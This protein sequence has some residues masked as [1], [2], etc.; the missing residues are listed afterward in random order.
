ML[1][2]KQVVLLWKF[3][4]I[5][6]PPAYKVAAFTI[7]VTGTSGSIT[8]EATYDLFIKNIASDPALSSPANGTIGVDTEPQL[9]WN[10][11]FGALSYEYQI[12][13]LPNGGDV[14]ANG[15]TASTSITV[16][17]ELD[18]ATMYYWRVRSINDCGTSSWSEE[19]SFYKN[20]NY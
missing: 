9:I 5:K 6:N 15:S 8:R 16:A 20:E 17:T 10:S 1:S 3:S 11:E 12:S 4:E 7:K 13:L 2:H 19:W 18:L 14:V